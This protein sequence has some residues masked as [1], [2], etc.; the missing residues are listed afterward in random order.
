MRDISIS[1]HKD[2][3]TI[4]FSVSQIYSTETF[5]NSMLSQVKFGI[6]ALE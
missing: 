3:E 2:D 6:V 1:Q 4:G 5:P